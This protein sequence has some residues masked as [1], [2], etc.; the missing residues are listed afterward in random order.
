MNESEMRD[1]V[2]AAYGRW[3]SAFN[4]GDAAGIAALYAPHACFLPATHEVCVGPEQIRRFFAG[5]L[6]G[7]LTGHA[8]EILEVGGDGGL[9]HSATRWTARGRGDDGR[10]AVFSGLALHVLERLEDGTVRIVAHSFN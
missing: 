4:R 1:I 7:G 5:V 10:E 3:N 9:I 6:A 2:E 8:N